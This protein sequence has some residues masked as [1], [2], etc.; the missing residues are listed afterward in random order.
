MAVVNYIYTHHHAKADKT[1]K[2]P[3]Y[4]FESAN[5]PEDLTNL[6]IIPEF[7]NLS[8]NILCE[9]PTKNTFRYRIVNNSDTEYTFWI[10]QKITNTNK[11]VYKPDHLL[12]IKVPAHSIKYYTYDKAEMITEASI[13]VYTKNK[14][15]FM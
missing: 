5:S 3:G 9:N 13:G 1:V 10:F 2:W 11:Q 7:W 12:E 15:S 8:E 4:T 6:T 14:G